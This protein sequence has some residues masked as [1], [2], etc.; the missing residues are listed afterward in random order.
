MSKTCRYK[1][2]VID[3]QDILEI[4]RLTR[5]VNQA[6]KRPE[7]VLR[8]DAP[9]DQDD[10]RLSY[11]NII[12]DQGEKVFKMWY[13]VEGSESQ[14]AG[15]WTGGVMKLA[16]ATSLDGIH[17]QRPEL[18]LV[19]INGPKKNNYI[20]PEKCMYGATLIDDPSDIPARRYKMIFSTL[21]REVQ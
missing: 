17:W 18:G 1:F 6:V 19:E 15:V 8:M 20:L 2:L 4:N 3:S 12:Y 10:E 9:W 11:S 21:G 16:Y 13:C 14:G 5:K 7:P